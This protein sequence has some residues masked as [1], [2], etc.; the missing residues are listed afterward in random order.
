MASFDMI[1][2]VGN[3]YLT[4]W[5]E[6]RYLLRMA[7]IPLVIK[8]VCYSLSLAYGGEGD[9]IRLS[10]FMLPAYFAEGWLL[11]HWV[12]TIVLGHRWPFRPSGDDKADIAILKERGR[13]VMSGTVAFT[14]INLLMAGYFAF[15]ISYIPLDMNPEN[16][17]PKV[18]MI[19]V[20]MMVSTLLLFRFVWIY[21]ALAV[22][23]PIV[24]YIKKLKHLSSTFLMIGLWLV[25]FVPAIILL[26][27]SGSI[28]NHLGGDENTI[29]I[30]EAIVVF[31]RIF[32]DMVKNLIVTAGMAYAFIEFFKWPKRDG[33]A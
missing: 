30:A 17:D 27:F 12:R 22:N 7:L 28:L 9:I 21:V 14:L 1:T 29:Q 26:Q 19:G 18:A 33:A 5:K 16:A 11:A 3:A 23:F 31:I 13:G 24:S 2:A 8:Y 15:F 6:R 4:T 20:A 10:L 32:L 25:C